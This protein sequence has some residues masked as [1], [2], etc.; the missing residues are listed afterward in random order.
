MRGEHINHESCTHSFPPSLHN[1]SNDA[2]GL[3][4]DFG[5]KRASFNTRGETS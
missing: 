2:L 5:G 1:I 4:A 3:Q